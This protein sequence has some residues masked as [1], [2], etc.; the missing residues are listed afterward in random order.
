[1]PLGEVKRLYIES[2]ED[3]LADSTVDWYD[4]M[5]NAMVN[6]IGHRKPIPE[7][8]T[9]D[10]RGWRTSMRESRV[11]Y[12]SKSSSRPKK[13]AAL[14]PH[15]INSHIRASKTFFNWCVEEGYLKESPAGR[16]KLVKTPPKRPKGISNDERDKLIEVAAH[17]SPRDLAIVLF[18]ADTGCRIGGLISLELSKVDLKNNLAIVTEKGDKDRTVYFTETTANAL[19][20]YLMERPRSKSEQL[21]L[22]HQGKPI[23]S[24]GIYQMLG[25]IAKK[26]GV[27]KFN[28]HSF[29]HAFAREFLLKGGSLPPLSQLLGHV[30]TSITAEYY[31]IHT[32]SELG[33]MHR[34]FS[35]LSDLEEDD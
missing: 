15:S 24:N 12:A 6:F 3:V 20:L 33:Q 11:R 27:K 14:S 1:M 9:H 4:R 21:F 28:P 31:A 5:L 7:V 16:L 29:R 26:A 10:L 17:N 22:S 2:I 13:A 8:T 34:K 23:K 30:D 32:N 35:P 18:L 19:R 25:R